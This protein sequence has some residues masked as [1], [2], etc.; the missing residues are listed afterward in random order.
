MN[1]GGGIDS[2]YVKD[3][4]TLIMNGGIHVILH[5]PLAIL[6]ISGGIPTYY[7]CSLIT[8]DYS[9]A[10]SGGCFITSAKENTDII[11]ISLFPN[12]VANELRIQ[13]AELRIEEIEIYNVLGEKC[14]TPSLSKGEGASINVSSLSAGIYFVRVKTNEGIRESKFVK[15]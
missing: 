15:E 4:A 13:N 1:T 3:G 12:P 14:L 9:N 6:N 8:F 10:P 2:I 5:E 11:S 7:P